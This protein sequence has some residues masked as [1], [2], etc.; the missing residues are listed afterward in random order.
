[1]SWTVYT[2]TWTKDGLG[3]YIATGPAKTRFDIPH[4]DG[5]TGQQNLHV[6]FKVTGS[7]V[8]RVRGLVGLADADNYLAAEVYIDDTGCYFLRLYQVSGGTETQLGD[9]QAIWLPVFDEEYDLKVCWD[10]NTY[11]GYTGEGTLRANISGGGLEQSFGNQ[12]SA[13]ADGGYVGLEV[14]E[15][16]AYF[17]KFKYNFM[18]SPDNRPECPNCN[19][20]QCLISSDDFTDAAKSAC[21]WDGGS[22]SSG[23]FT[24]TGFT[25]H[26]VFH[27]SLKPSMR[28]TV[29]LTDWEVGRTATVYVNAEDS[30]NALYATFDGTSSH[31]RV[32]LYNSGTEL[33]HKTINTAPVGTSSLN[34]VLCY[35][36]FALTVQTTGSV[37]LCADAASD[38]ITDGIYAALGGSATWAGWSLAKVKDSNEP[39]DNCPDCE[40]CPVECDNCLDNDA[41]DLL[42]LV[43]QGFGPMFPGLVYGCEEAQ[44]D[45]LNGTYVAAKLGAG[46]TWQATTTKPNDPPTACGGLGSVFGVVLIGP[47]E[48]IPSLTG[49]IATSYQLWGYFRN[50]GL[51]L[52]QSMDWWVDLGATKPDCHSWSGL[53]LAAFDYGPTADGCQ[54]L[55]P[56]LVTSL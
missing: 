40:S 14:V 22:A 18:G 39:V 43:L 12:A 21:L 7:G 33:A 34:I 3:H 50:S 17:S 5:P 48:A 2:G 26:L 53:S 24:T 27:P 42:K 16:T 20:P 41:P 4:P 29:T 30:S 23:I 6:K 54:T 56:L 49:G 52:S 9:D 36:G 28:V 8:A 11:G 13:T 47:G 19:T 35:D 51:S 1:M 44:C 55:S 37:A 46:C 38:S 15:G 31:Q 10:P 32:T 45:E 25:K